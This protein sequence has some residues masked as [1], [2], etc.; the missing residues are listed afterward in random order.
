MRRLGHVALYSGV[1]VL[2]TLWLCTKKRTKREIT[3]A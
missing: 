3:H 1:L 2:G